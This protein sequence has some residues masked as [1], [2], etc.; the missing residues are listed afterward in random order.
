M[1]LTRD[2]RF[3]CLAWVCKRHACMLIFSR[4]GSLDERVN[5]HIRYIHATTIIQYY[6]HYRHHVKTPTPKEQNTFIADGCSS[7]P[8]RD[9]SPYHQRPH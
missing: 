1:M 6:P 7:T 8:T 2:T 3:R 5:H 9:K 4:L